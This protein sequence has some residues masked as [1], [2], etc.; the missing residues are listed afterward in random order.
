M[1]NCT[2]D[3]RDIDDG[4]ASL[5]L[6][7]SSKYKTIVVVGRLGHVKL[8]ILVFGICRRNETLMRFTHKLL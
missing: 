1:V 4:M 6:Y 7:G 3:S 2:L 5:V 8:L